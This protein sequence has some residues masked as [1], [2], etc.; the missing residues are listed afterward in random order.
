[1]HES[2]C[3]CCIHWLSL[4]AAMCTS[5]QQ[6]ERCGAERLVIV[7]PDEWERG[8][9]R[10]KDLTARDEKDLAVDELLANSHCVGQG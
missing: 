8:M 3:R 10:V 6:A 5:L 2:S 7:A 9:V 4:T 1:M